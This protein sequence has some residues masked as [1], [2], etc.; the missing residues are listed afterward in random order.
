MLWGFDVNKM[1]IWHVYAYIWCSIVKKRLVTNWKMKIRCRVWEQ[2]SPPLGGNFILR[3]LQYTH[4][5]TDTHTPTGTETTPHVL[6][7]PSTS[8]I[9]VH[10]R[11]QHPLAGPQS[12]AVTS[13]AS[14]RLVE[15]CFLL[16][17]AKRVPINF[18]LMYFCHIFKKVVRV[19]VESPQRGGEWEL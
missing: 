14:A 4:T 12:S 5:H 8:P 17:P 16:S 2:Y 11:L 7:S 6:M 9:S 15:V 3:C 10:Q 18:L 19:F 13:P 1:N